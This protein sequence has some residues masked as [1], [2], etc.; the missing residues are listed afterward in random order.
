MDSD[1]MLKKIKQN[2]K[3]PQ[4]VTENVYDSIVNKR[5][6]VGDELPSEK[7]LS[8]M[9]EISRGS[10]REGLA[11]LEFFGVIESKKNRRIVIRDR[12]RTEKILSLFKI[13]NN[14]DIIL[15]FMEIRKI[16]EAFSV[17]LACSRASK[18]DLNMMKKYIDELAKQDNL[19]DTRL[20][21]CFHNTIARATHNSF[22]ALVEELLMHVLDSFRKRVVSD[23]SRKDKIV[24]EHRNIYE[25]IKSGDVNQAQEK[26]LEHLDNVLKEI[27]KE[28][29]EGNE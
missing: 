5:I 4:L 23:K 9:F 1:K 29:K 3:I 24:R 27:I 12:L 8:E 15:D 18:Y 26:M 21:Q 28:E 25:A 19:V 11:I 6:K 2:P 10:L 7:E 17:K 16:F 13:S 14:K 22:I 20:N